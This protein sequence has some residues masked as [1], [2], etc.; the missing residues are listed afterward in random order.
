MQQALSPPAASA[1]PATVPVI[2]AEPV[3]NAAAQA[4]VS[5][6]LRQ[7]LPSRPAEMSPALAAE[8]AVGVIDRA[9]QRLAGGP[10]QIALHLPIPLPALA[11]GA[12]RDRV[13]PALQRV[14]A[15]LRDLLVLEISEIPEGVSPGELSEAVSLLAPYARAVLGR[16]AAESVDPAAWSGCGLQGVSLDCRHLS[17]GDREALGKLTRFVESAQAVGGP[18][19]AYGLRSRPLLMAA[20]AAGCTHLSGSAVSVNDLPGPGAVSFQPRDLFAAELR[21]LDPMLAWAPAR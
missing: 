6:A 1:R 20:W 21:D 17:T 11:L 15:G 19:V 2:V 8:I 14:P 9:I 10:P 18:C 4:I 5:C 7:T 13:L 3:W 16:A 12:P